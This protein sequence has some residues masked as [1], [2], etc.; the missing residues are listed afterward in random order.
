MTDLSSSQ[1]NHSDGLARLAETV[2]QS[3]GRG[4]AP[5]HLWDPPYC[6]EIGMRIASDGTWFYQGSPIGRKPLVRLFA[7]VLRKDEDGRHYLVTPVEKI[8]VDVDDAP[9][10]AVEMAVTG[11]GEAQRLAFRTNVDDLV[12]VDA[13]NPFRFEIER[14]TGGLRPYVLVRGRL[15]AR[16]T[17]AVTYD[18]VALAKAYNDEFGVWSGRTFFAMAPVAE[19][20]LA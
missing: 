1:A 11:E 20:G 16:V 6:G 19:A 14:E 18:L 5:V 10:Q 8:G 3:G 15:E 9:F 12:D 2:R 7:S 4:A 17:R 13:D